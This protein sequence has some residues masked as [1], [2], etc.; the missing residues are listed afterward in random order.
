MQ[1]LSRLLLTGNPREEDVRGEPVPGI[2]LSMNEIRVKAHTNLRHAS[3][4]NFVGNHP[5][6]DG[7]QQS[8]HPRDQIQIPARKRGQRRPLF[9]QDVGIR[10]TQGVERRCPG[11]WRPKHVESTEKLIQPLL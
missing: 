2:G 1:E 11:S 10:H 7:D 4:S 3:I 5:V 8:D 6:P 9:S